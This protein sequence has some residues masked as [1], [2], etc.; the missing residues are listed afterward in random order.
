MDPR[1]RAVISRLA[2]IISDE[3]AAP[4]SFDIPNLSLPELETL[5]S[6]PN[7]ILQKI[8]EGGALFSTRSRPIKFKYVLSHTK[9]T[10]VTWPIPLR[11]DVFLLSGGAWAIGSACDASHQHLFMW[12]IING[13]EI[14]PSAR[15]RLSSRN[16]IKATI[17]VEPSDEPKQLVVSLAMPG[18]QAYRK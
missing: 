15:L 2:K 1:R 11:S 18:H 3:A 6:R 7:T 17:D 10:E 14:F 8:R 9:E 4:G 16:R 12:N 5:A 13:E